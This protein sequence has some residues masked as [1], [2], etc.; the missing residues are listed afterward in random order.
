MK[1]LFTLAVIITINISVFAQAPNKMSYQCVVRNTSGALVTNQSIGVKITILQDTPDGTVVYQ[2]LFTPNPETNANGLLSIEIGTGLPITGIFSSINWAEGPYYLKTEIDP[3]GTTNY[4]IEGTSQLL[5]VPYAFYSG[6]AGEPADNSVTSAKIA[7]GT[8]VAADLADNS[9]TAAKIADGSVTSAK[10]AE[11]AITASNL[12]DNSVTSA[13]IADG[14]IVTADLA[15]GSVTSEKI[16]DGTISAIDLADGSVTSIKIAVDAIHTSNLTDNSVTSV[17]IADGTIATEDLADGSVTSAKIADGTISNADL[18][19]GS[20]TSEKIADAGV[21]TVNL[22][23]NSVT[24]AKIANGSVTTAKIAEEAIS[25][26]KLADNSITSAKIAD[27]TIATADLAN[28]SVTS[29]KI[30]DG[31]IAAEDLANGSVTSA[32]IADGTIATADLA[33]SSV[34]SA[35]IS[36]SGANANNVLQYTGTSVV[37]DYAPGS[38]IRY[39]Y[40]NADCNQLANFTGTFQRIGNIGTVFKV[41]PGSRLEVSYYGRV[42]VEDVTTTGAYFE[43][44]V[45]DVAT[46][47][48]RANIHVKKSEIGHSGISA[49]FTAVFSGLSAGNHTISMWVRAQGTGTGT[50]AGYNPGCW[51]GDYVI[52]REIK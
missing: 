4:T 9:V 2:E 24:T 36:G 31:T 45:D 52:V 34:T 18:G 48:G 16:A 6:I 12:A 42:S 37:W 39:T 20:V 7:D 8:I 25:A 10:I 29:E 11:E 49:F 26:S 30:A 33:N 19:N 28:G 38:I 40:L 46:T 47:N 43:M 15:N 22:A 17:K 51:L 23:N 21:T 27:G 32:K 3:I 1:Q 14:T 5:S 50:Y 44:R 41:D 13:K 35:K